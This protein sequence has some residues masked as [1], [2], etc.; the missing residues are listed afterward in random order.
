MGVK[1]GPS[2]WGRNLGWRC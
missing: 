1:L 2:N